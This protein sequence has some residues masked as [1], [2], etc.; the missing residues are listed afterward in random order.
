MPAQDSTSLKDSLR[1]DRNMLNQV[2]LGKGRCVKDVQDYISS[3]DDIR[4][5]FLK[6][7][8]IELLNI[9]QKAKMCWHKD[10]QS[11]LKRVGGEQRD[12]VTYTNPMGTRQIPAKKVPHRPLTRGSV[13]EDDGLTGVLC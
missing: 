10:A 13:D 3:H 2:R 1:Y 8:N 6:A 9:K 4:K 12:L 5:K 7:R 11:H